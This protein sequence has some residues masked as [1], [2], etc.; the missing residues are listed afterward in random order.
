MFI[1]PA[2]NREIFTARVLLA[3]AV[4]SLCV[5]V[6]LTIL[7]GRRAIPPGTNAI[8]ALSFALPLYLISIALGAVLCRRLERGE[9]E[10][11]EA[12]RAAEENWE[13][14]LQAIE[15]LK[16]A[17]EESSPTVP[18][19]GITTLESSPTVAGT[20]ITTLPLELLV[21]IM[22]RLPP[23]DLA[24][25]V[26]V[27][28]D[29]NQIPREDSVLNKRHHLHAYYIRTC[30]QAESPKKVEAL[31]EIA[32]LFALWGH[33]NTAIEAVQKISDQ[34]VRLVT[35]L[36]IMHQMR[37][38][39][40]DAQVTAYGTAAIKPMTELCRGIRNKLKCMIHLV[41]AK[42]YAVTGDI[43]TALDTL[44][45][46][47]KLEV[48]CEDKFRR[49]VLQLLLEI[50]RMHLAEQD[51]IKADR[52]LQISTF[53][54]ALHDVYDEEEAVTILLAGLDNP[55][56]RDS[57]CY[58][59]RIFV[60]KENF[61]RAEELRDHLRGSHYLY[62]DFLIKKGRIMQAPTQERERLLA[63]EIGLE[64]HVGDQKEK[65]PRNDA[66][67]KQIALKKE[68]EQFRD[69]SICRQLF[70][71]QLYSMEELELLYIYEEYPEEYPGTEANHDDFLPR[72]FSAREACARFFLQ[73]K[74]MKLCESVAPC[75]DRGFQLQEHL[76]Y[77]ALQ[78][79]GEAPSALIRLAEYEMKTGYHERA[80]VLL[81][82]AASFIQP[83]GTYHPRWERK[84]REELSYLYAKLGA[85]DRALEVS[86][87]DGF[88]GYLEALRP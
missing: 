49:K 12:R 13:A 75:S 26:Q 73:F 55:S 60:N 76:F 18:G 74:R 28:K 1:L 84:I 21:N 31:Q 82:R 53:D 2:S 77:L 62:A 7:I 41:N 14:A 44:D 20:G 51:R 68:E 85:Y 24:C 66:P 30:G 46:L 39:G 50:H 11:I 43:T 45:K 67:V 23:R 42:Y 83:D 80:R 78:C 52:L 58:C 54:R 38:K 4:T 48:D 10:W 16:E 81:E 33:F 71:P 9:L 19:T 61:A 25:C 88:R 70:W 6:A 64:D 63:K 3:M 69:M 36:D 86:G 35:S 47:Q 15:L 56:F 29:W 57:L 87:R 32:H 65:L 34:E 40:K 5:A 37:L 22:N 72:D 8:V 17:P 59:I 79:G 27:C